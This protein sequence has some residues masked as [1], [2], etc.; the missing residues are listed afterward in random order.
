MRVRILGVVMVAV[1]GIGAAACSGDGERAADA[2]T[3]AGPDPVEL[4]VDLAGITE[5]WMAE[6]GVPG[7]SLAVLGPDGFELAEAVGVADLRTGEPV[8]TDDYWRFASVTK[9]MTS[10][11]VL[12]LAAD[13]DIDLDAPVAEYLGSGWAEGY[14]WE[15]EDVG[16]QLTVAQ[17]LNHTAGFGEYAF[18][19]GF[20]LQMSTRLDQALEP[21]EIIDWA[22]ANGPQ[23]EPG[24][25]YLY[26]TVGHNVAGL[27]IEEV[28][29]TPAHVVLREVL[30]DPAGATNAYLTPAEFPD[31]D[32]VAGYARGELADALA[33]LPALGGFVEDAS[34]GE[35]VDITVA[36]QEVLT[37]AGWTGGGIEA[38][39]TDIARIIRAMFDGTVLDEASIERFTEKVDG[40]N[41]A[42]GISVDEFDGYTA[43]SHGGGVPGFRSHAVYIP[44]L[45]LAL[46]VSSNLVPID[47][48]IGSLVDELLG[49]VLAAY[50]DAELV[51]A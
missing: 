45:D 10:T 17:M 20:Y 12:A 40:Q 19:P 1:L 33:A 49:A 38:R 14:V 46:A 44:E 30:F 31:T 48:D 22:I 16:D 2:A 27:I 35:Y 8:T 43:Y 24:N 18:D 21:Q 15:G 29:G 9:P 5:T 36:P 34:V 37:S 51:A 26:N 7:V 23:Y 6:N 11:V 4:A 41:Y 3:D 50:D 47:P 39:A 13:G 32:V 25:G 28:T 42:L